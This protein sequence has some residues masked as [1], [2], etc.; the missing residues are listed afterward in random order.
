MQY[1]EVVS[2]VQRSIIYDDQGWP[3][4]VVVPYD[5]WLKDQ[6]KPPAKAKRA[7]AKKVFRAGDVK[8]KLNWPVDPVEFQRQMR[9]ECPS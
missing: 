2:H 7:A 4:G 9:E 5:E 3:I 6:K 1:H 8:G